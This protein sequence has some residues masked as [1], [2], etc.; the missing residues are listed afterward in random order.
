M[1]TVERAVP[2]VDLGAQCESISVAGQAADEILSLP[3]YMELPQDD[4]GH[5]V[6][7]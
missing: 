7:A 5:V 4:T 2:L 6:E 1:E 3:T